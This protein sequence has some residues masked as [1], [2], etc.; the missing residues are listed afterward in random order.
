MVPLT[1]MSSSSPVIRNEIEPFR[2]S[3][4][5]GEIVQHRRDAAGDAAL[6]VDGAAAV[7]KAVL[8][9][10]GERAMGPCALVARR[11]HVGMAGKGDVRRAGADAGIEVVDIG[12]AGFAEGDAMHLEAGGLQ[13]VFEDAERAGVGRGYGGAAQQ[14]AGD[15]EG[16]RVRSCLRLTWPHAGGPAPGAEKFQPLRR[17][18]RDGMDADIASGQRIGPKPVGPRVPLRQNISTKPQTLR[19]AP[20]RLTRNAAVGLSSQSQTLSSRG[21]TMKNTTIHQP[22]LSRSC[23]R[24]MAMAAKHHMLMMIAGPSVPSSNAITS[25]APIWDR[26]CRSCRRD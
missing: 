8:D 14:V 16:G 1:E 3:A 2:L 4:V 22:L 25:G 20:S 12:G 24:L 21:G 26:H 23:S 15:G 17:C 6:H 7:Q 11:H 19:T 18:G 13:D 5:G 10:A 9:V